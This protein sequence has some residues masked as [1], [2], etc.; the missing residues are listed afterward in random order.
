[1][2]ITPVLQRF[3]YSLWLWQDKYNRG[4]PIVMARI[5]FAR[6]RWWVGELTPTMGVNLVELRQRLLHDHTSYTFN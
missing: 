2:N 1:M 5:T 6:P 4:A 3:E